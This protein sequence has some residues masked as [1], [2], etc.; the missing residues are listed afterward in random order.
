M[1]KLTPHKAAHKISELKRFLYLR[2]SG[3][4][5]VISCTAG[6]GATLTEGTCVDSRLLGSPAPPAG[7][8]VAP[9]SAEKPNDMNGFCLA[10]SVELI[11][12]MPVTVSVLIK[13]PFGFNKILEC[14]QNLHF[15]NGASTKD[16]IFFGRYVGFPKSDAGYL[17]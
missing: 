4:S 10:S 6:V 15:H 8:L 13:I 9:A 17:K 3:V 12:V 11:R 5:D 14:L 16:I 2:I 1:S 7:G